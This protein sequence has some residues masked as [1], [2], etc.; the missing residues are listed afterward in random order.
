MTRVD[1][2]VTLP[3]AETLRPAIN[4]AIKEAL[5][6]KQVPLGH[7]VALLNER[8]RL[9]EE[10]IIAAA[11]LRDRDAEI[12]LLGKEIELLKASHD[13]KLLMAMQ[14]RTR[15]EDIESALSKCL[16]LATNFREG[17]I[18]AEES[19]CRIID[20]TCYTLAGGHV[21]VGARGMG[22]DAS[23]AAVMDRLF[24]PETTAIVLPAAVP[25]PVISLP[26]DEPPTVQEE[27]LA[28]SEADELEA[29]WLTRIPPA[30]PLVAQEEPVVPPE[31]HVP[32][33]VKRR[34]AIARTNGAKGGRKP[35]RTPKEERA[36]VAEYQK[37]TPLK[38]IESTFGL[39]K[40]GLYSILKRHGV[41]RGKPGTNTRR[42]PAPPPT[43]SAPSQE[44]P[45][46]EHRWIPPE[47][48]PN[49][50]APPPAPV[51][52]PPAVTVDVISAHVD[53]D[54]A[55]QIKTALG[56]GLQ[57]VLKVIQQAHDDGLITACAQA[58][59]NGEYQSWRDRAM[60]G[61]R[62]AK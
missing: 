4:S 5:D 38:S 44:L 45:R 48:P 10:M 50:A 59:N 25:G 28:A 47:P 61:L 17:L 41:P 36:I 39:S 33:V 55:D 2:G 54:T 16:D 18:S 23:P 6:L 53:G 21:P 12:E 49:R 46:S 22:E 56:I 19:A 9:S 13:E 20:L 35:T 3:D 1:D 27:P 24:G 58:K 11:K 26:E 42:G 40:Q 37:G 51:H 32:A 15:I 34:A 30:L 29:E 43:V 7:A 62:G 14:R 8:D 57:D 31:P 52:L 60:A